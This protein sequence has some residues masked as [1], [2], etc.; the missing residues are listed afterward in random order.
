MTWRLR[1][2][3]PR[4]SGPS[5]GRDRTERWVSGG[6]DECRSRMSSAPP[7][8]DR[9]CSLTS[10]MRHLPSS[11]QVLAVLLVPLLLLAAT[12]QSYTV[13]RCRFDGVARLSCCCPEASPAR[14]EAVLSKGCCCDIDHVQRVAPSATSRPPEA[15]IGPAPVLL[16]SGGASPEVGERFIRP[17]LPELTA[18]SHGPPLIL[19]KHAFLI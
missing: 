14:A 3:R 8:P 5:S 2:T 12:A 9:L 6:R 10:V 4:R 15:K 1:G 19:L 11:R 16:V 7:K 13:F 18:R 17:R